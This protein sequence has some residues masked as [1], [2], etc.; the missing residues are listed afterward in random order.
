MKISGVV[1]NEL[2]ATCQPA[3]TYCHLLLKPSLCIFDLACAMKMITLVASFK[4]LLSGHPGRLMPR[5]SSVDRSVNPRPP[6]LI[7]AALLE[8]PPS[9]QAENTE[10]EAGPQATL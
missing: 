3:L 6:R 8:L 7:P 10:S 4:R 1:T 9:Q 5:V 2:S